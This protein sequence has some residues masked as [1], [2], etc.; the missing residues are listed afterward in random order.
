M[1]DWR[2]F[3]LNE[4]FT[5]FVERKIIELVYGEDMAKLQATI[6]YNDY[7]EAVKT[8]GEDNSYTSLYPDIQNV[9]NIN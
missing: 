2:N 9:N 4:G 7:K 5:V 8:F 6:G 1:A 3:W